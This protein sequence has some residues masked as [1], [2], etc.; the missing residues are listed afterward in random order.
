MTILQKSTTPKIF[1]NFRISY[2]I[3]RQGVIIYN[4]T[5]GVHRV[6]GEVSILGDDQCLS[7]NG[8]AGGLI[9]RLSKIY[10]PVQN[11]VQKTHDLFTNLTEMGLD[12]N[13]N[14]KFVLK[15]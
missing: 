13:T 3:I 9:F 2:R 6:E 12:P 7:V 8:S 14:C 10:D 1:P 4:G 5:S 11:L 15:A